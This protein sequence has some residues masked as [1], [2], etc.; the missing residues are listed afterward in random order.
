MG[1]E[2]DNEDYDAP[3]FGLLREADHEARL[4]ALGPPQTPEF[5]RP[6]QLEAG[7]SRRTGTSSEVK[8]PICWTESW[9]GTY[10]S[11]AAFK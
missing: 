3:Q 1:T 10:S 6:R 11:G 7:P 2:S 4:D 8:L 9:L 5:H